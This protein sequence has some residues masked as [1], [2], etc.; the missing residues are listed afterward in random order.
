MI[1]GWENDSE[2]IQSA[3]L[4][5]DSSSG[6]ELHI[7][8]LWESSDEP[9]PQFA[10]A[11]S[12]FRQ[13]NEGLPKTLVFVDDGGVVTLN[14]L[15][16]SHVSIG[17]HPLGRARAGVVILARPRE[18]RDEYPVRQ[19]ASTI[20]GL[21]EFSR[22]E[23]ITHDV[24]YLPEGHSRTTIVVESV[25]SVEWVANGYTYAIKSNVAWSARDGRYFHAVDSQPYILT[26]SD[27]GA[28][29][30][31][32]LAAQW[33]LRAL[34]VLI[35]GQPLS[36][37]SHRLRDEEF[38]VWMMDGSIRTPSFVDVQ[39]Q[40]TIAEHV[41]SKPSSPHFPYPPL[42]L[43]SV[44]AEALAGWVTL[45]GDE[46]FAQ[47]VQ[48]AVEV[49]NGASQFLEPQLMM[50]AISLDRFG[51]FLHGDG[52]QRRIHANIEKCM[53][54]VGIAWPD[55]GS[56]RG[57]A[58]AI[59]NANNDLKHPDREASPPSRQLAGLVELCKI[60]VRAQAFELLSVDPNIREKFVTAS[61]DALNMLRIFSD[62]HL[63]ITDDG[64]FVL[65]EE[66]DPRG[67]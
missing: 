51:Y 12:W 30:V 19:L 65:R 58:R 67:V 4:T 17:S 28:S 35:H 38:P 14:D 23:P 21:E 42:S 41:A 20:D 60:I 66:Q 50:L 34:L 15:R 46:V 57:I 10:R 43:G 62:A 33:P 61:N 5:F 24:Q 54:A 6:A 29:P 18:V 32:H 44:T 56:R 26:T 39:F 11:N 55:L 48:P 13:F 64:E 52:R 8:Y 40:G 1:G 2:P 22:F 16:T 7:A 9:S 27:E 37:R 47:A 25:D 49:L 3:T 45:Y 63:M 53:E 59:A 36:W 31:E